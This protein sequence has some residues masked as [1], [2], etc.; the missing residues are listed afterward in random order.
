M[1]PAGAAE[2]KERPDLV[3]YLVDD[4]KKYRP[5]PLLGTATV[6]FESEK[7]YSDP[8]S[9]LT[10]VWIQNNLAKS[11]QLNEKSDREI[12]IGP[13]QFQ[14]RNIDLLVNASD[15][16]GRPRYPALAELR[17]LVP[18][19]RYA[20]VASDYEANYALADAY[21]HFVSNRLR[22]K[23]PALPWDDNTTIDKNHKAADL[24]V[25]R[26]PQIALIWSFNA[27][28]AEWKGVQRELD[29]LHPHK[30]LLQAP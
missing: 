2:Q 13:G 7:L 3:P 20:R 8:Y 21:Y 23:Q 24:W 19:K 25:R 5:D 17:K 12:S 14:L 15:S 1:P 16:A 9:I 29:I 18:K 22:Q 26:L 28:D 10:D 11:E 4:V 27:G 6:L 30:E